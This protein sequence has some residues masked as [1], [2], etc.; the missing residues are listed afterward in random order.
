MYADDLSAHTIDGTTNNMQT[1]INTINNWITV[2]GGNISEE[3][4]S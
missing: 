2:S 1:A 4:P 3:K